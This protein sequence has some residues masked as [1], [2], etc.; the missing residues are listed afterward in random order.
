MNFISAKRDYTST[1]SLSVGSNNRYASQ[2]SIST[3][4]A[5]VIR[6]CN[7]SGD[8]SVM[9]SRFKSV[10]DIKTMYIPMLNL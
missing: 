2:L 4:S 6:G 3:G 9:R 8:F 5:V 1:H 10:A 7:V